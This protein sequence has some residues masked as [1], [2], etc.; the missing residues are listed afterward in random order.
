MP[1]AADGIV[2]KTLEKSI[3]G[4]SPS[5]THVNQV[6]VPIK[7]A[8]LLRESGNCIDFITVP[9]I[10]FAIWDKCEDIIVTGNVDIKCDEELSNDGRPTSFS[11]V[12]RNAQN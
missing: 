6:L 5:G 8:R 7:Y 11:N 2:E 10:D 3:I 1:F 4:R 9:L 12:E